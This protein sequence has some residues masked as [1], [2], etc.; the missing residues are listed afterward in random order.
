LQWNPFAVKFPQLVPL[1]Q[2][3]PVKTVVTATET[4]C[5]RLDGEELMKNNQV[6]VL[7]LVKA[8]EGMEETVKQELM[9]LVNPTRSEVGCVNYDLHQSAEVKSLFMFYENWNSM[10]DLERHRGSA[11]LKAFRERAGGLLAK[12]IEVTLFK[13]IN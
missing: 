10:E 7:A 9:A 1:I 2:G 8:K 13:M 4:A 5:F 11:H 6:T 12:P 3:A